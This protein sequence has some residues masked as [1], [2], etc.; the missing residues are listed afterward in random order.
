MISFK[1]FSLIYIQ[2]SHFFV[3]LISFFG[4]LLPALDVNARDVNFLMRQPKS[5]N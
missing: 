1:S 2:F 5:I 4:G 3:G